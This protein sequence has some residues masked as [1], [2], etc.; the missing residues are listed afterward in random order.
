MTF[1]RLSEESF[2]SPPFLPPPSLWNRPPTFLSPSLQTS[3]MDR[4]RTACCSVFLS[5]GGGGGGLASLLEGGWGE[6]QQPKK[7]SGAERG[8]GGGG[9]PLYR[10]GKRRMDS[11]ASLS[12]SLFFA[13]AAMG[14]CKSG[15]G[16]GLFFHRR[17]R[18][19]VSD[20][21]GAGR[22]HGLAPLSP[23]PPPQASSR[24]SGRNFFSFYILSRR[25]KTRCIVFSVPA[26][27]Q[28]QLARRCSY[29]PS[30]CQ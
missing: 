23:S 17:G 12:L 29:I 26:L 3:D 14:K 6:A 28:R 19:S 1:R 9:A 24:R 8:G 20:G 10:T 16:G 27:C 25:Y 15:G 30:G 11:S 7:H 5:G 2:S 18:T 21:A 13:A 4:E 22:K